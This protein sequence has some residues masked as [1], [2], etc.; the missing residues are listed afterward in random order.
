MVLLLDMRI[1][2]NVTRQYL[3]G[4]S[5]CNVNF[6]DSISKDGGSIVGIEL[7]SSRYMEASTIFRHLSPDWFKHHTVNMHDISMIKSIEGA[8]NLKALEKIYRP[9]IKIVKD[10]LIKSKPD[11]VL[12]NGTYYVPWI[13][14]I[15]AHELK[16]PIVLR[17]AG[18][19]TKET[20]TCKPKLRKFFN[21]M[22]KSFYKR[23]SHYIFPSHLCQDV[24]EKEVIKKKLKNT[25][26]L[27]NP[28]QIPEGKSVFKSIERR[29]AAVGRWDRIKNFGAFFEIHRLLKKEG[30]RHEASFV[31]GSSK[32]K[33]FPKTINRFASMTH[34]ELL[35]FYSSQG[36]VICPSIFETFGNVP[37]EAVC[38][39][40]PVLVSDTMGCAEVLRQAGLDSMVMSF[41]DPKKV[42]E[43]V[44]KL[45]GQQ[46]LPKQINNLRRILDPDVI[47]AEM[48]SVLRSAIK[49]C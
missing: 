32:I 5:R 44:K 1:A 39:G 14:S 4:I 10:I 20:E 40:I 28:F 12:L 29:I 47:H 16:I 25:F 37:V 48:M 34:T 38:A 31:T 2:T 36:L 26:V 8:K 24:V 6:M 7:N 15:A 17:Y 18:V 49:S 41:N 27:P 43:R 21:E 46:I 19:Y 9:I 3:G 42:V 33:R 30:W 11:V 45:C 35:K 23:V 22:E 13:M